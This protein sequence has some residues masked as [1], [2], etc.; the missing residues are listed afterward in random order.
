M[1]SVEKTTGPY[2]SAAGARISRDII[3]SEN[4]TLTNASHIK[5]L[6]I[7]RQIPVPHATTF[8]RIQW[9]IAGASLPL[10]ISSVLCVIPYD[11]RHSTNAMY[12]TENGVATHACVSVRSTMV[13]P[14]PIRCMAV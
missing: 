10:E 13:V 8:S 6:C 7:E 12:R 3:S 14:G 4:C 5:L 9:N 2:D 11:F 1:Q